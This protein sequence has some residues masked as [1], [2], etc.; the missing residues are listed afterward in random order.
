MQAGVALLGPALLLLQERLL[1]R[2]IL[3]QPVC[4]LIDIALVLRFE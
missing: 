1:L 3:I 2:F 4:L